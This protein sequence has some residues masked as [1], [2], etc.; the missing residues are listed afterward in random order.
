MATY[1]IYGETE[2][3]ENNLVVLSFRDAES[4]PEALT[5]GLLSPSLAGPKRLVE[6]FP[7][8]LLEEAFRS[9]EV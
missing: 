3:S 4:A 6:A 5:L 7:L 2:E 1:I 8:D 9:L